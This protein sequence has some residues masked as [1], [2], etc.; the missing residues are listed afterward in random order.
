VNATKMAEHMT[1]YALYSAEPLYNKWLEKYHFL[2]I[3]SSYDLVKYYAQFHPHAFW[4][5]HILNKSHGDQIWA[6]QPE[7]IQKNL[8]YF[9]TQYS[10]GSN[11]G[12]VSSRVQY[13]WPA[14]LETKT[15][16]VS[17]H[18]LYFVMEVD[19]HKKICN[20]PQVFASRHEALNMIKEEN[21]KNIKEKHHVFCI[22]HIIN[23]TPTAKLYAYEIDI[24]KFTT[25]LKECQI[26]HRV[27]QPD[28]E[29]SQPPFQL[30]LY[31]HPLTDE[32]I[33]QIQKQQYEEWM[34]WL[35][36]DTNAQLYIQAWATYHQQLEKEEVQAK[37]TQKTLTYKDLLNLPSNTQVKPLLQKSQ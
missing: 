20:Y 2:G 34:K 22:E 26:M 24:P 18:V 35:A 27:I 23:K 29:Y 21:K 3:F 4:T 13:G 10:Y 33:L 28:S 17:I 19:G 8:T 11:L 37:Q 1:I 31:I 16:L 6:C 30:N 5:E 25:N 9:A 12:L 14:S 15:G 32:E 36:T 7:Y